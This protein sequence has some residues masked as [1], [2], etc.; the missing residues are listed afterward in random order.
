MLNKH[1]NIA[2][3]ANKILPQEVT[4]QVFLHLVPSET[5]R[6]FCIS[7]DDVYWL[8]KTFTIQLCYTDI[9]K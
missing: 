4:P 7:Y 8:F 9:N 2:N 5:A 6:M 1:C 3:I